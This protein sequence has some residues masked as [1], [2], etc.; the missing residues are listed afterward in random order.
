M[1]SRRTI[2]GLLRC[3]LGWSGVVVSDD[4]RMGAIEQHYG[5]EEAVAL[6]L[7]AG[8]DVLL[9]AEDRLPDGRSAATVALDA[10]RAALREGRLSVAAVE[11]ALA[12]VERLKRALA[13]RP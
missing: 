2:A 5:M 6:A 8:V 4:L 11:T 13:A 9:I 12:R 1:L 7:A 10:I 3:E